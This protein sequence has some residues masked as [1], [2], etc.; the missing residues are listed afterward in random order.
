MHNDHGA[1]PSV[2]AARRSRGSLAA[3][4]CAFAVLVLSATWVVTTWS[5]PAARATAPTA[6]SPDGGV[7]PTAVPPEA[8]DDGALPADRDITPFDTWHPAVRR[9]D[10]RLLKAVQEAARDAREDGV[11][12][13]VTSG[14]RSKEHQQ[15]LLEEGI[16]KHGSLEKAREFVN[17]PEKSTHVSGEA[18]DIGPTDADDWLIR[19][20]SAY[21]LCQAYANE[22]WHFELLTSPG[23]ICPTPRNNA[24]G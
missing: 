21:G 17:T 23:G 18:V 22:L 13:V 6:H 3:G 10:R 4:I 11:A 5:E 8:D 1:S 15:R 7:A 24:A 16:E 20:G 19:F 14:W 2:T 12:F 9:L